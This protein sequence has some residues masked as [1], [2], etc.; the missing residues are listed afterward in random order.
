MKNPTWLMTL[1]AAGAS[2]LAACQASAP[3]ESAHLTDQSIV[4]GTVD[5]GHPSVVG[6]VSL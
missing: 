2:G 4:R 6:V 1:I 3:D 5:D